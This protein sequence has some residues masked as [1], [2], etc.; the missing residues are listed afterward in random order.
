MLDSMAEWMRIVDI[1]A[2]PSCFWFSYIQFG[3][4]FGAEVIELGMKRVYVIWN[5]IMPSVKIV[6]IYEKSYFCLK[7]IESV[8]NRVKMV[9]KNLEN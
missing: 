5:D 7:K 2:C 1:E 8:V 3:D 4:S 6:R 9:Q